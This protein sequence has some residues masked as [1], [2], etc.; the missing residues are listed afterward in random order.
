MKQILGWK[1]LPFVFLFI[2]PLFSQIYIN[3]WM[4]QNSS[5]HADEAGEFDDWI[6]LY[7]GGDGLI[8]LTG[9]YISDDA[10]DPTKF[11]IDTT[12]L[13]LP[14]QFVLIWADKDPEQGKLHTNFKLSGEGEEIILLDANQNE[15]DHISF[16]AQMEDHSMGRYSDGMENIFFFDVPT[17]G[18]ANT[19]SSLMGTA[20]A[21]IFDM[22]GGFYDDN[23]QVTLSSPTV[24]GVIYYTTNGED[25][26]M[27]KN[28]Y[29]GPIPISETTII[30]AIV[31][32]DNYIQS[33]IVSE[34]YFV[35]QHYDLPVLNITTDP[36]N[37]WGEDGIYSNP[38]KEG[39]EWERFCQ[40][41]YFKEE[42]LEFSIN[43][44]IR[45]QGNSSVGLP[46]KSFRLFFDSDY[47]SKHLNYPMFGEEEISQFRNLVLRAGY[48]DDITIDGGTLLRDPTCNELFKQTGGIVSEGEWAI[49]TING[50][51][52]GIYEIRESMNDHFMDDKT[53]W[54]EYDLI[55]FTKS[56]P[57]V[58]NGTIDEWNAL[59][60]FL[61]NNDLSDPV[62]YMQVEEMIDMESLETLFAFINGV[63][64]TSWNW[65]VFAYKEKT[66][67]GKWRF[68]TW[69]LDN[70]LTR[71]SRKSFWEWA[72]DSPFHWSNFIPR[73]LEVNEKFRNNML[74]RTADLMNANYAYEAGSLLIDGFKNDIKSEMDKELARWNPEMSVADW[75]YNV[76]RLDTFLIERPDEFRDHA[77]RYWD[78]NDVN[79]LVLDV[80]G[81]GR[82]HL[83]TIDVPT[84]PW[85]GVYFEGIPIKLTAIA[86][87]GYYFSGWSDPNL[88]NEKTIEIDFEDTYNLTAIFVEGSTR[89]AN[90]VINEIN[91]H[92]LD[93]LNSGDWV[94][95]YNA[96]DT[97][98]DLSAWILEDESGNFFN[99]PNNTIIPAGGYLVLGEDPN[100]FASIYP[101]VNNF[102]G[103]FGEQDFGS[104]KL[105]NDGEKIS[106][107]NA[108]RSF[109]DTVHYN[110]QLPWP[111]AADGDGPTLQLIHHSLDNAIAENW[112][113]D[114]PTPGSGLM[115][116]NTITHSSCPENQVILAP[117]G[118]PS[119][120]VSWTLPVAVSTCGLSPIE[121]NLVTDLENNS[122]F[123][124]GTNTVTYEATDVCGSMSTC[125]FNIT[126][127]AQAAVMNVTCPSANVI[128]SAPVGTTQIVANWTE[129]TAVSDCSL[130]AAILTQTDGL[131][132]GA[133]FPVGTS[134]ISYKAQDA[135]ENVETCTFNVVVEQADLEADFDCPENIVLGALAGTDGR[136]VTW[137]MP[138]GT[139][140]CELTIPTVTQINGPENGSF[141]PIGTTTIEYEYSTG[142][143]LNLTCSFDIIVQATDVVADFVCPENLVFNAPIGAE[144]MIVNWPI[145]EGTTNCE[146]ANPTITQINGPENGSF[147]LVGINTIEYTY[148]TGCNLDLNCSF[149]IEVKG[150]TAVLEMSCL[151][152][153]VITS[154]VGSTGAV[155]DWIEPTGTSDCSLGAA[156]I[157]QIGGLSNGSEFPVGTSMVSYQSQDGCG[158]VATCIFEVIVKQDELDFKINN[159]ID[160]IIETI[161]AGA[162][163]LNVAW[164]MPSGITNCEVGESNLIQT[165]GLDNGSF[166]PVGT[167]LIEYTFESCGM[168]TTCSFNLTIQE[169]VQTSTN[170]L[171]SALAKKIKIFPNPVKDEIQIELGELKEQV[172]SLGIYNYLGQRLKTVTQVNDLN[173]FDLSDYKTGVYLIAINLKDENILTKV[174]VKE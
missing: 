32:A 93:D 57:E 62:I 42:Q 164:P 134:V 101:N 13:I 59:T 163:G 167:T 91:Y 115:L 104:F 118:A 54:D 26:N 170:E 46:K 61:L 45:I 128:F 116:E 127:E 103:G 6:E 70:A 5:I 55:R 111:V 130:G 108:N 68:M 10:N 154:L 92:S 168:S 107:H 95:L 28:V 49:L 110:D 113:H 20:Q 129:P 122:S 172:L 17:P 120:V 52:W 18:E 64:Y 87:P 65:G 73:E 126:V 141:L 2:T 155:V 119:A 85:T 135:C 123:L 11:K 162:M 30:R 96:E 89:I 112:L 82:V 138:E 152:N 142:C 3:E 63:S 44:G 80:Q 40:I 144:G 35:N 133:E 48:D 157:E 98:V 100:K 1:L 99:L 71:T 149:D 160:E 8:D 83:N 161:P 12:V 148:S 124:I 125:S 21:P 106:I 97:E 159:C 14:N 136:I 143:D 47:G 174:F 15:L 66:T 153:I 72:N 53:G 79:E 33:E 4:A 51:F 94:E 7:N 140:N 39:S 74:N 41:Q 86:E 37:M 132:N 34:S 16:T 9:F 117:I 22:T 131:S 38:T 50:D 78:L 60:A 90:V 67:S 76:R 84:Y 105:S 171:I 151:E 43:S 158:N 102:I 23:I 150:Q 29:S 173:I 81:N 146:T 75:E 145:P 109:T 139:T 88:P 77:V 31:I 121:Q 36:M 169:D 19:S 58:K 56:G 69:D 27:T 25:P 24:G 147:L 137:P 156:N 166:F 165:A 114:A